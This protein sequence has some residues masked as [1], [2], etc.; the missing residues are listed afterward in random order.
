MII[1]IKSLLR[2]H[3]TGQS[4]VLIDTP[5]LAGKTKCKLTGKLFNAG[6]D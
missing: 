6:Q 2:G 5:Y 3:S 4:T 1:I